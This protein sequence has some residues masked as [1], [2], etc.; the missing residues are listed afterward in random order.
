MLCC[1]SDFVD[2]SS[3]YHEAWPVLHSKLLVHV[4]DR[5]LSYQGFL[6]DGP[7]PPPMR[8][9]QNV[10]LSWYLTQDRHVFRRRPDRGHNQY[11]AYNELYRDFW[12]TVAAL[13]ELRYLRV[14]VYVR[15]MGRMSRRREDGDLPWAEARKRKGQRYVAENVEPWLEAMGLVK[16]VSRIDVRIGDLGSKGFDAAIS[17][18]KRKHEFGLNNSNFKDMPDPL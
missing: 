6:W 17:F 5:T 2:L 8:F 16:H 14:D 1:V 13:P 3:R 11:S 4:I 12:A 9:V 15:E 18:E 10:A 7:Y